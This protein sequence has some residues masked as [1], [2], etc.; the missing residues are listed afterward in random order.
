MDAVVL[1][2][3]NGATTI[4]GKR[5]SLFLFCLAL[6]KRRQFLVHFKVEETQPL[7]VPNGELKTRLATS[8]LAAGHL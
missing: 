3:Q 8:L 7:A 5:L 1:A 2:T 4:I 6:T